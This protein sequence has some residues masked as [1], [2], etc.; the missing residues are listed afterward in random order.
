MKHVIMLAITIAVSSLSYGQNK[1]TN[2][3]EMYFATVD[4][5]YLIHKEINKSSSMPLFISLDNFYTPF[6]VLQSQHVLPKDVTFCWDKDLKKKITLRCPCAY[7]WE[8]GIG[9]DK[10]RIVI[11]AWEYVVT[12]KKGIIK[13]GRST[14]YTL[15]YQYIDDGWAPLKTSVGQI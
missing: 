8:F 7:L 9:V 12:K 6:R 4:S 14:Y 2:L 10:D 11:W 1:F 15:F 13:C 3:E 5:F